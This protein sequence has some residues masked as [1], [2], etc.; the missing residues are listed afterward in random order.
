MS[1]LTA[2]LGMTLDTSGVTTGSNQARSSFDS[3]VQAAQASFYGLSQ[4]GVGLKQV[5]DSLLGVASSIVNTATDIQAAQEKVT[6]QIYNFNASASQNAAVNQQMANAAVELAGKLAQP[7][8]NIQALE[9]QIASFGIHGQQDIQT[10]ATTITELATDTNTAATQIAAPFN[11]TAELFGINATQATGLANA[12]RALSVN[13]TGGA[14]AFLLQIDRTAGLGQSLGLTTVQS[15]AFA[16]EVADV[17]GRVRG[18]GQTFQIFGKQVFD[19]VQAGGDKLN[20]LASLSGETTDQ[21]KQQWQTDRLG[22]IQAVLAGF[23]QVPIAERQTIEANIGITGQQAQAF[24]ILAQAAARPGKS[25]QDFATTAQQA[26]GNSGQL[27]TVYAGYLGT[28]AAKE[29]QMRVEIQHFAELIGQNILPLLNTFLGFVTDIV[30]AV[31]SIPGG[32]QFLAIGVALEFVAGIIAVVLGTLV[33][34]AT[35]ILIVKGAW[36]QWQL[37]MVEGANAQATATANFATAMEETDAAIIAAQEQ[38]TAAIESSNAAVVESF[39][40]AEASVSSFYAKLGLSSE[41]DAYIAASRNVVI[42]NK[43]VVTSDEEIV[44]A[45]QQV[46]ASAENAGAGMATAIP[47]IGLF[48]TAGLSI[49]RS[50]DQ[51]KTSIDQF[52]SS[53]SQTKGNSSV[54]D[55]NAQID[56]L[57]QK[58]KSVS[59]PNSGGLFNLKELEGVYGFV[60]GLVQAK[61][62]TDET[63]QKIA[64]LQQELRN[65]A[66]VAQDFG[67]TLEQ[68]FALSTQTG[69]GLQGT[70]TDVE[71]RLREAQANMSSGLGGGTGNQQTQKITDAQ[72]TALINYEKELHTVADSTN[73]VA[74]AQANLATQMRNVADIAAQVAD[75]QRKVAEAQI[76]VQTSNITVLQDSL[77]VQ[78]AAQDQAFALTDA[79]NAVADA[80]QRE[81]DNTNAVVKAQKALQ[82]LNGPDYM[83]QYQQA[84]NAVADASISLTDEQKKA[85]DAQ[86]YLNY[87]L[88]EGASARDIQDARDALAAA[89]Q[90]VTDT[91]TNLAAAQDKVASMPTDHTQQVADATNALANARTAA[92]RDTEALAKAEEALQKQQILNANNVDIRSATLALEDAQYKQKDAT[93]AVITAEENLNKI[94]DGSSQNALRSAITGVTNA[95]WS[96]AE[97]LTKLQVD[98][99][100]MNGKTDDAATQ[101]QILANNLIK[102]GQ[103]AGNMDLVNA[104]NDILNHLVVPVQQA[105]TSWQQLAQISGETLLGLQN[106][107]GR[108]AAHGYAPPSYA[109]L[110][111]GYKGG[112]IINKDQ[113]AVL[114]A[115]EVVIPMNDMGAA[116]GLLQQS[117]LLDMITGYIP[118]TAMIAGSYSYSTSNSSRG[119]DTLQLTAITTADPMEIVDSFFWG[120]AV[121]S[122]S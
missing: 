5:G 7:I 103:A 68:A 9:A 62:A 29:V 27:A 60:N 89:N 112:G 61:S 119:G 21:F 31:E 105:I 69:V 17:D 73:A 82:D 12:I 18:A 45:N 110:V 91:T 36:D 32:A 48:I 30:K 116:M 47:V 42:A 81:V 117:G 52:A 43:A 55:L 37:S 63:K 93:Y 20:Q 115:P 83:I 106:D 59:D 41:Y 53:L 118:Q 114:H 101:A 104:G 100:A 64:D 15:L 2:Q 92:S 99:D 8:G 46:A 94:Q 85:G 50:Y 1:D 4:V 44:V 23:A 56:A 72:T 40:V 76:A 22:A 96:Q 13:I 111:P 3:L 121:R 113:L 10:V 11:R 39:T 51:A 65:A 102:V 19:A 108:A 71:R 109:G 98:Q 26:F 86:W 58:L 70:I 107:L 78:F 79:E 38:M 25:L 84:I 90:K 54:A 57:Q 88:Q 97:A 95:L 24:D 67:I 14:D 77:K 87:L 28:T 75:A 80:R 34:L 120:Q 6:T 49:K 33:T 122:R 35:R 66:Q 74:S 16:A